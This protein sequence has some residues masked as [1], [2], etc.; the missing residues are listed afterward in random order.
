MDC[1]FSRKNGKGKVSKVLASERMDRKEARKD[2]E[3]KVCKKLRTARMTVGKG[4]V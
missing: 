3:M 4:E 2:C 1:K